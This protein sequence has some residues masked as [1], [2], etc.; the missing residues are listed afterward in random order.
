LLKDTQIDNLSVHVVWSSQTGAKEKHVAGGTALMPDE[1]AA[2]Y[3][4]PD[5]LVGIAF[6][7]HIPDLE[8]PAWDVW[9]LFAPGVTWGERAPPPAPTWWEHQLGRL[10]QHSELRLDPDRFARKAVELSQGSS[11]KP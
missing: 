1:R 11:E 9:M 6:Q 7:P 10:T 5:R 4:D 8:F 3:W 2:H